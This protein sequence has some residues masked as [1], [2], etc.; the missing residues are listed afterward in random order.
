MFPNVLV[1]GK[2]GSGKDT[3]GD[4]LCEQYG[5]ERL[6]FAGPLKRK[7]RDLW[8]DLDWTKKQRPLLQSFGSA[9]REIDPLTW[10]KLADRDAQFC[11]ST[12]VPVVVTDCRYLNEYDYFSSREWMCIYLDCDFDL[13]VERLVLRDGECD[14][15]ALQHV[16]ETDMDN[17]DVIH[18]N[19]ES[20][21]DELNLMVR[22]VLRL[23]KLTRWS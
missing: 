16:S 2:A 22:Y 20:T 23:P 14:L 21:V 12:H 7:A 10:I 13:R 18:V 8:P 1:A 15:Q 19:N 3:V 5:Y 11:N 9:C 6:S 17:I 4:L